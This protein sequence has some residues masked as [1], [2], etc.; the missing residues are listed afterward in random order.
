MKYC[1]TK[2]FKEC[3]NDSQTDCIVSDGNCNS[4]FFLYS[5]CAKTCVPNQI[6]SVKNC[7]L[8]GMNVASSRVY[9]LSE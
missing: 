2:K 6:E 3:T 5:Y 8:I 7:I 4:F 1:F 9:L